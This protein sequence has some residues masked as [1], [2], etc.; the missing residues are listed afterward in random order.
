MLQMGPICIT[1]PYY[2]DDIEIMRNEILRMKSNVHRM[3][4]MLENNYICSKY[5]EEEWQKFKKLLR[6]KRNEQ[7]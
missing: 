4:Y 3:E 6:I 7:I 2:D 1:I 5:S